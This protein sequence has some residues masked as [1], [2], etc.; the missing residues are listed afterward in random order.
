MPGIM[1]RPPRDPAERI[2]SWH[3][4]RRIAGE[5]MALSAGALAAFFLGRYWLY[6][7]EGGVSAS[8]TMVFAALV[9][10]QL[11]HALNCRSEEQSF[12]MLRPA[13]PAPLLLAML[14]SL[15]MLALVLWVPPLMRA[16]RTVSLNAAAWLVVLACAVAP[17]LA[18][19]R[20]KAWR[21]PRH[22][23]GSRG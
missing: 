14:G 22:S 23:S 2:L 10:A 8:Q 6:P 5:G 1:L 20:L 12:L 11:L 18:V 4:V 19:D 13:A 17:P 9:L 21:P 16:F 7:G 15:V 3:R